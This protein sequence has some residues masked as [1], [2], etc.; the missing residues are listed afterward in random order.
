MAAALNGQTVQFG[1]EDWCRGGFRFDRSQSVPWRSLVNDGGVR[2]LREL[3][4]QDDGSAR[5]VA[6]L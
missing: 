5:T 1:D 3:V 4:P 2:L 6:A